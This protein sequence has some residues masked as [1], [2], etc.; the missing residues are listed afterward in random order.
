MN[1]GPRCRARNK[2][3]PYADAGHSARFLLARPLRW[4]GHAGGFALLLRRGRA[5][6]ASVPWVKTGL[7]SIR[8]LD[9]QQPGLLAQI[10]RAVEDIRG[11]CRGGCLV[12]FQSPSLPVVDEGV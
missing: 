2:T 8:K 9:R 4:H 10:Q 11:S 6:P 1:R 3:D 5:S 7:L 12:H